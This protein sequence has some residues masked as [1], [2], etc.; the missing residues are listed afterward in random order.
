MLSRCLVGSLVFS[1]LSLASCQSTSPEVIAIAA[2]DSKIEASVYVQGTV[3]D[4]APLLNQTAY[5]LQDNTG[6]IWVIT[7]NLAP[8]SGQTITIQAKIK[9]KSMV[10][11]QQ[12]A[13]ELYLQEVQRLP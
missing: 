13:Q 12:R 9:S 7:N 1:L 11:H 6:K 5:Q 10:L 2:L 8:E 4:R 3:R